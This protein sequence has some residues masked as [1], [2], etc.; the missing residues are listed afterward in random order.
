MA[1]YARVLLLLGL[2]I[3]QAAFAQAYPTKPVRT[4]MTIA[5]GAEVVARLIAQG[6]T[7][8]LGQPVIVESQPGA[9][10]AIGVEM[11]ARGAPDGYP[12]MLA[13]ASNIVGRQFLV[14]SWAI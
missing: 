4:I 1:P 13:A 10:D 14:K 5:G 2:D 8:A 7:T 6:L 9:G 3:S 11:V 12:I